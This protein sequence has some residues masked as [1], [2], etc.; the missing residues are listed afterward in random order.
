VRS[1]PLQALGAAVRQARERRG[2]SQ[3]RCGELAHLHRNEIGAIERGEKNVSFTNLLRVCAA[4]GIAPSD[5][6]K[7]FGIPSLSR[8]PMKQHRTQ[9]REK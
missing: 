2:I 6:L 3:E 8:L 5:L 9:R 4:L 7:N 1:D